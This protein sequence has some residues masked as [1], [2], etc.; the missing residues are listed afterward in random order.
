MA[1]TILVVEDE[2]DIATII[3]FNLKRSGFD[4]LMAYDGPT[5]LKLA[6]ENAPDLILLDVMLPGMD[7]FEICRRVREKSQVPIIM[8]TA[9]EEESDKILGL[10][11]GAD[12]Y[13]T[14]PFSNRE[15]IARIK[16]N[17]RRFSAAE[18][19]QEKTD[20]GVGLSISEEDTAVYKDGKPIDLSVREFD[21]LSYL[22]AEPGRVVSRE[23]LMEKVWGFEYYGDLRAV[24]VAIRRLREKIEDEPAQPKYIITKRG[25]GYYF[26]KN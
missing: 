12:D 11:L 4:T 17:M 6:L 19:P 22:A 14:K 26:A 15:L 1:K 21:I 20:A 16:A 23:E 13:V 25:L 9:R 2:Q 10:E 8:L 7:G 24:D 5:G 18:V 3:D